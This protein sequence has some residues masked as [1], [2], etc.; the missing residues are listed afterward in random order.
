MGGRGKEGGQKPRGKSFDSTL[1]TGNY[2]PGPGYAGQCMW[3]KE[4]RAWT[5]EQL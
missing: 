4:R 5:A 1:L 2:G 3:G